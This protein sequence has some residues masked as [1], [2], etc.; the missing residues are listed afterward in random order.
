MCRCAHGYRGPNCY[1]SDGMCVYKY[2]R[3]CIW[4]CCEVL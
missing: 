4:E 3:L 2:A 1:E